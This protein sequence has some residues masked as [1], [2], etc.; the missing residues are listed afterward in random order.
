MRGRIDRKVN[1]FT[2]FWAL[3]VWAAHFS[4]AWT[5]SIVFPG[6]PLARWLGVLTTFAALAALAWLGARARAAQGGTLAWLGI[7]IAGVA[8]VWQTLPAVV[9]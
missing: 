4:A 6:Q 5:W 9:G 1:W 3:V 2:A 8:V 7:G